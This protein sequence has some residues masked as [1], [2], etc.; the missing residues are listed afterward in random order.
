M[1]G[2][3]EKVVG[4]IADKRRWREYRERVKT[5][6]GGY[7]EAAEALERYLLYRGVIAKG[8]V[9]VSL[10][11]ELVGGFERAAAEGTPIR[12]VVGADP[13]EF[14]DALLAKYAAG[15]WIDKERQ[16]LV[17]AIARAEAEDGGARA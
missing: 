8:D 15:E 14:A 7:W 2:F 3:I 6:P 5:L 17:D 4:D 13:V 11:E 10:H 16:R 1:S 12:Q 9:L